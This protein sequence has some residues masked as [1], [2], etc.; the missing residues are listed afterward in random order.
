VSIFKRIKD[1]WTEVNKPDEQLERAL[2]QA[3][4]ECESEL[5][6]L[7]VAEAK[8]RAAALLANPDRFQCIETPPTEADRCWLEALAPLQRGFFERYR[9]VHA[10]HGDEW[11]ER[12]DVSFER[13][14]WNDQTWIYIGGEG[15]HDY[16]LSKR[17]EEA[18]YSCGESTLDVEGPVKQAESIYHYL[19]C[20]DHVNES[21]RVLPQET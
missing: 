7:Q 12:N 11:F 20:T 2:D 3:Y 19:L 16:L 17:G 8:C 4:E 13:H 1:W 15:F 14:G 5:K 6:P 18:I 9:R 10:M 21:C